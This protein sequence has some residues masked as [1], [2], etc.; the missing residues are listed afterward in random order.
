MPAV[1]EHDLPGPVGGR[2][3]HQR[4]AEVRRR[5]GDVPVGNGDEAVDVGVGRRRRARAR[6]RR[7]GAA[8]ARTR[9]STGPRARSGTAGR[10][11]RRTAAR[12]ARPLASAAHQDVVAVP[13]EAGQR[14]GERQHPAGADGRDR[15]HARGRR[16]GDGRRTA[17]ADGGHQRRKSSSVGCRAFAVADS[18][19]SYPT[20]CISQP[21]DRVRQVDV[22]GLGELR[23]QRERAVGVDLLD[24]L[25]RATARAPTSAEPRSCAF[26]DHVEIGQVG[27]QLRSGRR[28][29][30]SAMRPHDREQVVARRPERLG[31]GRGRPAAS[32]C[33]RPGGS[34]GVPDVPSHAP[35]VLS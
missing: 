25:E 6:R 12:T 8:P 16:G 9:G 10:R 28:P 32:R 11:G 33:R 21:H 1:G 18:A 7:R 34:T 20:F 27:G 4:G 30:R 31:P 14:L 22:L 17:S 24:P 15:A 19:A 35:V 23:V 5:R 2:V 13:G 29:C 26:I 3:D